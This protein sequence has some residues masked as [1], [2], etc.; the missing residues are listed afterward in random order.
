[1]HLRALG[2]DRYELY[3]GYNQ[4]EYAYMLDY[5]LTL[6]A[7]VTVTAPQAFRS[8]YTAR[9]RELVARYE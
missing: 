9:L 7:D 5:L 8:G 6:G 3:G 2:D 4:D 1:M